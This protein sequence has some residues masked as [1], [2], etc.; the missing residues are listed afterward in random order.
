MFQARSWTELLMNVVKLHSIIQQESI[1]HINS[2]YI[3]SIQHACPRAYQLLLFRSIMVHGKTITN[4]RGIIYLPALDSCWRICWV[5]KVC[6]GEWKWNPRLFSL[7]KTKLYWLLV[8]QMLH[9]ISLSTL[10]NVICDFLAIRAFLVNIF[11]AK[12]KWKQTWSLAY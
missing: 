7:L 9:E 10:Q 5:I 6:M 12:K 11:F 4:F 1:Y 3:L 8:L 2:N